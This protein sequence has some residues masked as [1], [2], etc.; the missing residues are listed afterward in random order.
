MKNIELLRQ[1]G[2]SGHA[3]EVYVALLEGGSQTVASI[4]RKAKIERP[5]VY[6]SLPTLLEKSLIAKMPK[7]KRTYYSAL[8]PAKLKVL[9]GE[10]DTALDETL[11]SLRERFEQMGDRPHVTFLEGRQGIIYVY[12]DILTTLPPGG[13]FY[14]Y[15]SK[16][17]PRK[18]GF[19]V[20]KNYRERRDA[21]KLERFVI[22]NKQNVT[23]KKP[24]L[25]R[26]TKTVP[27]GSELF[28]YNI[29]ELIYGPKIAFVDYN[30]ETAIIIENPV[31]AKFQERLF[32]L[33]YQRL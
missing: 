15:S 4:A 24:R 30:T 6:R 13:V 1:L 29:T 20:P 2:L 7:G 14:R 33:L 32:K 3:A 11:P 22:T 17:H 21:K 18:E 19:Y 5:L 8:S 10:L 23:H 16:D 28:A 27:Q 9:I 31:I 26:A 12:E 25:E